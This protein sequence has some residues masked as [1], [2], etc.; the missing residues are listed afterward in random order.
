MNQMKAPREA[1]MPL[2]HMHAACTHVCTRECTHVCTRE[3]VGRESL[4]SG[5]P[6]PEGVTPEQSLGRASHLVGGS[7]FGSQQEQDPRE[8][9]EHG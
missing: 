7:W 2:E 9:T 6:F 4:P 5:S 8:Q 1:R 3:H